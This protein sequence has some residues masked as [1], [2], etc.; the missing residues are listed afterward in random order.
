LAAVKTIGMALVAFFAAWVAFGSVS[1]NDSDF[2]T[3]Q[4]FGQL[5]HGFYLSFRISVFNDEVLSFNIVK[6]T[7]PLLKCLNLP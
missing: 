7:Q 1:H 5:G 6:L 3:H 2:E 4:L